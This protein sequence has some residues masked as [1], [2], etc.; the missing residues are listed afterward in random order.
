MELTKQEFKKVDDIV[1]GIVSRYKT[2][3]F[4]DTDNDDLYQDLWVQA[5]NTI[6]HYNECNL[7]LIAVSLFNKCKLKGRYT[8][9]RKQKGEY[10]GLDAELESLQNHSRLSPTNI[11]ENGYNYIALRNST[12]DKNN[13][14]RD[15]IL[16]SVKKYYGKES[17]E[18]KYVLLEA[19][20][21]SDDPKDKSLQTIVFGKEFKAL[22]RSIAKRCGYVADTSSGY[23]H[24]KKKVRNY[25]RS[26]GY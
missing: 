26:I 24:M 9:Y 7:K 6:N 13:V 2:Y 14:L 4:Q 22:E 5:L 20:K 19:L 10:F 18:Y 23:Q 17:R 11:K 21:V 16:E 1:K 25:L 8:N 3:D 12:K 15:D